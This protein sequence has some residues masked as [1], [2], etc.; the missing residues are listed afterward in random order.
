MQNL[1]WYFASFQAFAAGQSTPYS[2]ASDVSSFS[3]NSPSVQY[4]SQG[5]L[6]Q[7]AGKLSA[8]APADQSQQ[9]AYT[10]SPGKFASFAAPAA[11]GPVTF[12]AAAPQ[13]AQKYTFAAPAYSAGAPS[14]YQ[15]AASPQQVLYAAAPQH[16]AFQSFAGG[17][18]LQAAQSQQL[19]AVAP[20]QQAAYNRYFGGAADGYSAQ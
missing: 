6:Q 16:P 15:F 4:N 9:F 13:S 2:P 10:A 7:L 1:P 5:Y 20:S 8:A 12:A 18:P 17:V 3:F 11:A 14:K 19:Y